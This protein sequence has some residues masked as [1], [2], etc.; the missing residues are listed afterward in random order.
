MASAHAFDLLGTYLYQPDFEHEVNPIYRFLVS[1]GIDVGWREA[2]LGKT[3]FTLVT[4]LMLWYFVKRRKRYY[5]ASGSDFRVFITT[6]VYGRPLSWL[7]SLYCLPNKWGG[8]LLYP[9]GMMPFLSL[10]MFYLGYG[11]MAAKYG[12]PD[13]PSLRVGYDWLDL[14]MIVFAS[15]V[16]LVPGW[17]MWIEYRSMPLPTKPPAPG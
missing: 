10:Y 12:W 8:F 6:Y 7:Q 14:T 17:Q 13:I 1:R 9:C 5:P 2:I 3:M 15:A 11:N 16:V 4:G